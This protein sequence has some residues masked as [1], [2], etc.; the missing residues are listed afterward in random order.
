MSSAQRIGTRTWLWLPLCLLLAL[1]CQKSLEDQLADARLQQEIGSW[2]ESVAQLEAILDEHPDDP[3]ANLLLG[4]AQIRLGQ[5]ALAIWPLEVA[6]RAPEFADKADLAIGSAYV[7][8][9]QNDAAIAAADRVLA[10]DPTDPTIRSA[11]LRLRATAHLSARNWEAALEDV[12]RLLALE[13]DDPDALALM[14]QALM[15]A[16]RIDEAEEV[17]RRIWESP[18]TRQ[19][20]AAGQAGITLVRLYAYHREDMAAADRQLEALLDRFPQ[21]P[22]VRSF[23]VDFLEHHDRGER[24][25]EMLQVALERDP[26]DLQL[27]GQLADLLLAQGRSGEAESLLVEASELFD[28][29]QAWLMLSDLHRKEERFDDALRTLERALELLPGMPDPLR[30]RYAGALADAGQLDRAAEVADQLEGTAHRNVMLGRLALLRGD[31]ERALRYFDKGLHEWPNN[32]GARY[33]AAKAAMALGDLD[34]AIEELREATRTGMDQTDAPLELALIYL[35]LGR[36]A[37]AVATAGLLMREAESKMGPRV[38]SAAVLLARGQWALG[39]KDAARLTLD[40]LDKLGGH[41]RLVAME[42]A[43]FVA[44]EDGIAAATRSLA[45]APLDWTDPE[46]EPALRLLGDWLVESGQGGKALE[47]ADAAVEAHPDVAAFHDIRGRVLV[48]VGRGNEAVAAFDRAIELD[49]EHAPAYEAKAVLLLMASQPEPAL[50]LL[51]RAS[52]LDPVNA[53]YPYQAAQVEL[54]AGRTEQ[55]E[56][57]LR[58]VLER[59]PVHAHASNDL[60]WILAERGEDLDLALRLA[61]RAAA[62]DPS[63]S[64]LDTLGWVRF[65]RGEFAAAVSALE[66]ALALEPASPSVAYRLGLAAM[67]G[68]DR[69]R[70]AGLFRQALSGGTFPEAEAARAQL[71]QLDPGAS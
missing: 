68:G 12:E 49:P 6:G 50:E 14:A 63:A 20:P 51:D 7:R 40:Q 46:N 16:E 58:T 8:L 70:A 61:E 5:P 54:A 43:R 18:A 29:P 31:P 37:S 36:P 32:A 42:R 39:S 65:R 52:E 45:K 53:A 35:K 34:R 2:Q 66:R 41:E 28:S 55:A 22:S 71:A 56:A 9:Q 1:G 33:L 15:G 67:E 17:V 11:A 44:E 47:R 64:V 23:V 57:R 59:D 48:N 60:A 27:R 10:R 62:A 4:N 21:E 69:E 24:A 19:T 25:A 38:I 26:G 3:E 13:P 30:F